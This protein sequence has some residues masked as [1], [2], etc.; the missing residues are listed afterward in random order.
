MCSSPRWPCTLGWLTII[1]GE[2]ERSYS[3][4]EKIHFELNLPNWRSMQMTKAN[5]NVALWSCSCTLH[6]CCW[7]VGESVES[8]VHANA[9]ICGR[10]LWVMNERVVPVRHRNLAERVS[11]PK[12]KSLSVKLLREKNKKINTSRYSFMKTCKN[13]Q[14]LSAELDFLA[15][16]RWSKIHRMK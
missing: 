15:F 6:A 2:F 13:L 11:R 3:G 14:A 5:F 8:S 16:S 12:A 7:S 9:N 4:C 10:S 1:Q